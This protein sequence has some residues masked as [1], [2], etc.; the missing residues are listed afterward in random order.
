MKVD[1]DGCLRVAVR[2]KFNDKFSAWVAASSESVTKSDANSYGV[3]IETN[4]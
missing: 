4:F 3:G 1:T 2:M